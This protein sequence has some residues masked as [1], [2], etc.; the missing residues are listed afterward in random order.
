MKN[1]TNKKVADSVK[2]LV[3]KAVVGF[4]KLEKKGAKIV[5]KAEG[6]WQ[7]TKPKRDKINVQI[8]KAVKKAENKTKKIVRKGVQIK[9]AIS[10][11]F[12]AG[13]KEGKMKIKK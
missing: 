9:N 8:N 13:V 4:D 7:S 11:G 3:V 1:N 5:K 12:K 10:K 2:K 6:E